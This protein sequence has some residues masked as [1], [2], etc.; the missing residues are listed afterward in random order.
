MRQEIFGYVVYKKKENQRQFYE[1][2]KKNIIRVF[3][4]NVS[5]SEETTN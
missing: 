1:K 2:G 3:R 4:K 5:P